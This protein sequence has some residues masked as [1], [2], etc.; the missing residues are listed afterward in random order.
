MPGEEHSEEQTPFLT[1]FKWRF[2]VEPKVKRPWVSPGRSRDDQRRNYDDRRSRRDRVHSKRSRSPSSESYSDDSVSRHRH[3]LSR[4][5]HHRSRS[6][7]QNCS[8]SS[9]PVAHRGQDGDVA[10]GSAPRSCRAS[11]FKGS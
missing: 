8:R 2:T 4:G 6:R 9:F 3:C 7:S 1:T 10:R 5:L 11:L